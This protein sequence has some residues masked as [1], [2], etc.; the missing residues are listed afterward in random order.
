MILALAYVFLNAKPVSLRRLFL[1]YIFS[2]AV[3]RCVLTTLDT[4]HAA[5]LACQ[6]SV[7]ITLAVWVYPLIRFL[8][9]ARRGRR[10]IEVL[11]PVSICVE[12]TY[13]VALAFALT[14]CMKV[15]VA[16]ADALS[17]A[18]L[19]RIAAASLVGGIVFVLGAPCLGTFDGNAFRGRYLVR[20]RVKRDS[21]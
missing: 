12:A 21:I 17:L 11:E 10:G 18:H 2:F 7:V 16:P 1:L 3:A 15:L 20:K 9:A 8:H 5:T 14:A 13:G 4:K 6:I 19:S